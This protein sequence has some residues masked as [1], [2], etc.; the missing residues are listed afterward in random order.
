VVGGILFSLVVVW[1]WW[2]CAAIALALAL[3]GDLPL[4][5]SGWLAE[6]KLRRSGRESLSRWSRM[7]RAWR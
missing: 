7:D 4:A 5:G 2:S 3:A 1:W 6:V